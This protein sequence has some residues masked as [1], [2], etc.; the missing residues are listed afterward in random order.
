[1]LKPFEARLRQDQGKE[2]TRQSQIFVLN[3]M[4]RF[5]KSLSK[6]GAKVEPIVPW[7]QGR[8]RL[9]ILEIFR[10]EKYGGTLY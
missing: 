2:R 4:G 3:P 10:S 1:M 9:R 6:Y 7:I 5:N 8:F